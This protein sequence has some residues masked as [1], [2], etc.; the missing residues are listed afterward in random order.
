M[1]WGR[2]KVDN[3]EVMGNLNKQAEIKL[4]NF[5]FV[6]PEFWFVA[7]FDFLFGV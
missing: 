7:S 2:G 4:W 5:L 1:F 6:P 3:E